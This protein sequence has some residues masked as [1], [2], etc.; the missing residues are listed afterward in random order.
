MQLTKKGFKKP[1]TGDANDLYVFVGDNMD[2]L[3]VELD[4]KSNVV[5]A[6]MTDSDSH[7]LAGEKGVVANHINDGSIHITSTERLNLN[8]SHAHSQ[9]HHAPSNAQKNSDITKAEIEDKLTGSISTH[10]HNYNDLIGKPYF[11]GATA[12][13]N[14][15]I[16]WIDT[17]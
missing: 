1:T 5:Q 4:K 6:H 14:K 9:V 3:E 11:A 7:F 16:F 2:L 12:P 15:N 13:V 8:I 10:T 17:N